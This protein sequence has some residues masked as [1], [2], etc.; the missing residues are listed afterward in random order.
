MDDPVQAVPVLTDDERR[1]VEAALPLIDRLV[2]AKELER[3]RRI[4]DA[5]VGKKFSQAT[6]ARMS[7]SQQRRWARIHAALAAV[8]EEPGPPD[9]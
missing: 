5:H 3:R 8:A 2:A 7:A 9:E 4:G 1:L 6:R